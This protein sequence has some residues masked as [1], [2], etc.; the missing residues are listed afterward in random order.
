MYFAPISIFLWFS[1]SKSPFQRFPSNFP[2]LT[3]S[4]LLPTSIFCSPSSF[5]RRN[6]LGRSNDNFLQ[7]P[8]TRPLPPPF[9][10]RPENTRI[11]RWLPSGRSTLHLSFPAAFF[12]Y[13]GKPPPPCTFLLIDD[14][15]FEKLPPFKVPLRSL[16][17]L[18]CAQFLR[19]DFSNFL[20]ERAPPTCSEFLI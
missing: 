13:E 5:C 10:P 14:C 2:T 19:S 8:P 17:P 16:S 7:T 12:F 9:S 3:W 18:S 6:G 1:R 4:T 11:Y 20:N 15:H